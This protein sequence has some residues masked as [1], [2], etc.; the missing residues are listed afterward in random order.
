MILSRS[1]AA[2]K[3]IKKL[4][5]YFARLSVMKPAEV[6]YRVIEHLK[7][8]ASRSDRRGWAQFAKIADGQLTDLEFLRRRLARTCEGPARRNIADSVFRIRSGKF[9]LLGKWWPTIDSADWRAGSPS[10]LIWLHDPVSGGSWPGSDTYCFAI[11]YRTTSLKYGDV[12]YVWE[13][14]RLQFLHPIAAEIA[15]TGDVALTRWAFR[16]VES[17]ADAHQPFRTVNWISGI[18]L[19]LR[20]VSI[21]LLVAAAGPAALTSAERILVRRLIAAHGYWL[22]RYPSR[23]SSANNHRVLEGLGLYVAGTLAPDLPDATTW[24]RDGRSILEIEARKQI[25][26]DGVGAEQSP[27]YQAFTME[28]LSFAALLA[29][30]CGMP[31]DSAVLDRLATGAE[32]LL[33]LLDDSGQAPAIGDNDEGRVI[34]QPPNYEPKYVASILG[35]VSGLV[36]RPDLAPPMHDLHL[37]DALFDAPE[38]LPNR[39]DGMRI[40]PTGGYTIVRDTISKRQIHLTFDHGP[41]GYLSLAAHGHADAL[42]IW[43]TLD[44][45]PLFIDAGTY[46]YHSGRAKRDQLRESAAHNTLLIADRSQ[47]AVSGPFIWA[48]KATAR[49][50]ASSPWPDWSVTGEHDGYRRLFGVQ[51]VRR[52]AREKAGI[53]IIDRLEGA[54]RPLPVTIHLLC[55]PQLTVSL[56]DR[57]I[58]VSRGIEVLA[59]IAPPPIFEVDVIVGEKESGRGWYSSR[60][61]EIAPAPQIVLSGEMNDQEMLTRITIVPPGAKLRPNG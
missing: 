30:G 17:W 31:L 52:I 21:A 57:E 37:R 32:H 14:N 18:E 60:F 59:R 3:R 7:K 19:A 41:L 26:S 55:H 28:A 12:K 54:S 16:L 13:F 47:S 5:W 6:F 10:A 45:Q 20:I 56:I 11:D 42:A 29:A 27:T 23:F 33:W 43:L 8:T 36:G 48:N 39:A 38:S 34:A 44:D 4:L 46:L 50:V 35:A 51:H 22:Y 15:H 25:F 53:S 1:F 58:A 2:N 24:V 61:G 49:L 40:F 9:E